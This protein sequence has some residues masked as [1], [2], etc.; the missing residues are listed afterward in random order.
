[1]Q[2][3]VKLFEMGVELEEMVQAGEISNYYIQDILAV[4]RTL[5]KVAADRQFVFPEESTFL[6]EKERI[7]KINRKYSSDPRDSQLG[8]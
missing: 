7:N 3:R 2:Y 8:K 1:M 5:K 6:D 4:A